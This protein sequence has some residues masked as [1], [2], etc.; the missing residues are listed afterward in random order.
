MYSNFQ[1]KRGLRLMYTS[2]NA[3]ISDVELP[4]LRG[5][6]YNDNTSYSNKPLHV[7]VCMYVCMCVSVA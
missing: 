3:F 2:C 5:H 1:I 6:G 7:Y 4:C